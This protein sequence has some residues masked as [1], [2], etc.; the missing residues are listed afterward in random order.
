MRMQT[1][2]NQQ[3]PNYDVTNTNVHVWQPRGRG[4][5]PDAPRHHKNTPSLVIWNVKM[6][7]TCEACNRIF[8]T[9]HQYDKHLELN[10]L[11]Q[12]YRCYHCHKNFRTKK[13]RI[14]HTITVHPNAQAKSYPPGAELILGIFQNGP[15][16]PPNLKSG[17]ELPH[18]ISKVGQ[19]VLKEKSHN[20]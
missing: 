10:H 6:T 20:R 15:T 1:T 2:A 12:Q 16:P 19:K 4:R 5:H 18:P 9:R 11:G 13:E 7:F 3:W 14:S 17:P 8:H